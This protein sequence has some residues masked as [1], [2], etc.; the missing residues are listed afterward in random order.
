MSDETH[1]SRLQRLCIKTFKVSERHASIQHACPSILSPTPSPEIHK[2]DVWPKHLYPVNPSSVES[3]GYLRSQLSNQTNFLAASV[4]LSRIMRLLHSVTLVTFSALV[5]GTPTDSVLQRRADDKY[6]TYAK[7][8]DDPP[9]RNSGYK[10]PAFPTRK[11]V[12]QAAFVDAVTLAG[13]AFEVTNDIETA[14]K[15]VAFVL[16]K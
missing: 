10:P 13:Y 12:V 4:N 14:K 2:V 1:C 7:N 9:P 8:C 6:D 15:S 16:R 5:A 3:S 11:S